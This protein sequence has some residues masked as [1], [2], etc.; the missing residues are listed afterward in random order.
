MNVNDRLV[1]KLLAI[2]LSFLLLA[3]LTGTVN[4]HAQGIDDALNRFK[5][6]VLLLRHPLQS[7]SQQYGSDG[8]V[9]SSAAEGAWT[10]YSGVLVDK[11][12]LQPDLLQIR[13]RRILF[14]FPDGRLTSMEFRTIKNRLYPPFPP[15]IKLEL[16]LDHAL[17][18]PEEVR[19]AIGRVFLMNTSD[20]VDALPE[21]WRGCLRDQLVYDPT[22]QPELSWRDP[23]RKQPGIQPSTAGAM[24]RTDP[25]DKIQTI[26]HVGSEVKP[27]AAIYS[28][29]PNFS[30]AARYEKFQGVVVMS[31]VIARD[32]SVRQVRLLRPVGMGLDDQAVA[33]VKTW[34][35]SPGTRN[36]EPVAIELNIEVA[37]NLY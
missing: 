6:K 29:E 36:G 3:L 27:P 33:R 2:R 21:F 16:Q 28:P 10:V 24:V 30:D 31:L 14:F 7:N 9:L 35:F 19:T 13:G 17:G 25:D 20:L 12:K 11:M 26:Y 23:P 1:G 32:G 37:F 22:A 34:R 8:K 5:G 18:S 4:A 15:Q